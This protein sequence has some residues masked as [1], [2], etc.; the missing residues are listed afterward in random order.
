MNPFKGS[1]CAKCGGM[2]LFRPDRLPICSECEKKFC[3][4][5]AKRVKGIKGKPVLHSLVVEE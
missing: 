5:A 2:M 1:R 4:S 3:E